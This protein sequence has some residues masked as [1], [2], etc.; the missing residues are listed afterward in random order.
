M[1][2]T[3][4]E[5]RGLILMAEIDDVANWCPKQVI[6]WFC[7]LDDG[8][9]HYIPNLE[10]AKV[11]GAQLLSLN[12][13]D[14][15]NLGV[16]A[17]GHQVLILDAAE[18]LK[19]LHY[20]LEGE[21]LQSRALD[22]NCR[23][24]ALR[25]HIS[26]RGHTNANGIEAF[27][28]GP[29][30]ALLKLAC[31]VLDS[32][33]LLV[34]WL[35]RPPFFSNNELQRVRSD[36]VR[37]SHELSTTVQQPVFACTIEDAVLAICA[38]MEGLS[39]Q[40]IA[41][42]DVMSIQPAFLEVT[43]LVNRDPSSGLGLFIKATFEGHHVITGTKEGSISSRIRR[44]AP[45]DEVVAVGSRNVVGWQLAKLVAALKETQ[46]DISITLKKRPQFTNSSN[47]LA[48]LSRRNQK[49]GRIL[50]AP[51]VVQPIQKVVEILSL[52]HI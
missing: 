46:S 6:D 36:V 37:L 2:Y 7:G 26:A 28:Q 42:N 25:S 15:E 3:G 32:T 39:H 1:L 13:E 30:V 44:I 52:I 5:R 22:L 14:L 10:E 34:M 8:L 18:L 38:D 16:S 48:P 27:R 47:M 4:N 51:P 21:N 49:H 33:K 45:G 41:S 12:Y 50:T 35:D 31:D 20:N 29:N 11:T 17:I 23:C 43:H 40:M 19:Q 9:Q 24:R